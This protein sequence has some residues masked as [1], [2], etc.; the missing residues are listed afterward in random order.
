MFGA[1]ARMEASLKVTV[2]ILGPGAWFARVLVAILILNGSGAFAA[3]DAAFK[4]GCSECHR[5][6]AKIARELEGATPEERA[7]LLSGFLEKHHA[8]DPEARAAVVEYLVGLRK[9]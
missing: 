4:S 7:R 3:D 8:P 2:P 5:S 1:I 6:A 9:D